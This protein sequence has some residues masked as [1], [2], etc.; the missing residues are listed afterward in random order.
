MVCWLA[1]NSMP[2][3]RLSSYLTICI[4]WDND[5][6]QIIPTPPFSYDIERCIHGEHPKITYN[7]N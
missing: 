7:F 3:I 1:V 6:F 2:I 5:L 4:M